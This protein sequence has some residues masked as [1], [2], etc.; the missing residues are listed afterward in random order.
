MTA[1]IVAFQKA[2]TQL[3]DPA[4]RRV[5]WRT[6]LLA[7][8]AY[9]IVWAV[10]W[11]AIWSFTYFDI[12]WLNELI[13]Y[14]GAFAVT[15]LSLLLFPAS[16]GMI[17]SIFLEEIADIV[18]ARHYPQLGKAGSVPI[19]LGLLSGVKF[20]LLL[21]AINLVLLPV[22]LVAMFFA[23]AGLVLAWLVNGWLIGNEYY[24]QV[25]LRR[26]PPAEVTAWRK[27]NAGR[28]W[29]AGVP[30]AVLS[31]VPFLNLL[32]PVIGCAMLVHVAQ[33]LK[34]PPHPAPATPF[35]RP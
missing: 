33:S 1:T 9:A 30:I 24:E 19:W 10:A 4:L 26:R 28:L 3:S 16:F 14:L 18:E 31:S 2:V 5:I 7:I 35:R 23:G 13:K 6:L 11:A 21:V 8:L 12:G 17:L 15:L 25:A 20:F 27:G 29:L 34:P 32:A 22:Y